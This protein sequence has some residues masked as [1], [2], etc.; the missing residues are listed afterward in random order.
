[1]NGFR[2][3][4]ALPDAENAG[5]ARGMGPYFD[6]HGR[7]AHLLNSLINTA[8]NSTD[9]TTITITGPVD[10][11]SSRNGPVGYSGL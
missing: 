2:T 11:T 7:L 10:M 5:P 4:P 9:R 3:A 6:S 8:R 1:M